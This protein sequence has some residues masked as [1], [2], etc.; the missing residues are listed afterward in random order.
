MARPVQGDHAESAGEQRRHEGAELLGAA[1]PSVH[2][3]DGRPAPPRP[4]GDPPRRAGDVE[5]LARPEESRNGTSAARGGVKNSR[6]AHRAASGGE[7]RALTPSAAR[8]IAKRSAAA[9]GRRPADR[10][11]GTSGA[12]V[13]AFRP[14]AGPERVRWS[15]RSP[16]A[17]RRSAAAR[18]GGGGRRRR[19]GKS[20]ARRPAARPRRRARATPRPG[21]AAAV[22]RDASPASPRRG[23]GRT[24][25]DRRRRGSGL[26]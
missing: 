17:L 11:A 14:A 10:R 16:L 26:R 6:S 23:R 7:R 1:A 13:R 22:S 12:N 5:P 4:D 21:R 8:T 15:C 3:I 25:R 18:D 2:E 19:T 20:A 24:A 9:R